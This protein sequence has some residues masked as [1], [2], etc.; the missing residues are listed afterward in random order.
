MKKTKRFSLIQSGFAPLI[1]ILVIAILGVMGYF[2]YKN[3]AQISNKTE[4]SNPSPNSVVSIPNL[5]S[6]LRGVPTYPNS[7]Y[8]PKYGKQE[9]YSSHYCGNQILCKAISYEFGTKDN[10]DSIFAWYK[11]QLPKGWK[12]IPTEKTTNGQYQNSYWG[13]TLIRGSET[14]FVNIDPSYG[15]AY[16]DTHNSTIIKP[17]SPFNWP[18]ASQDE[19]ANW[20]TFTSNDDLFTFKYPKDLFVGEGD[21]ITTIPYPSI[22]PSCG[23]V[24]SGL[25]IVVSQNTNN[26]TS[27]SYGLNSEKGDVPAAVI[28]KNKPSYFTGLDVSIFYG[29]GGAGTPGP[30]VY[31]ARNGKMIE[32]STDGVG[33]EKL[34]T[35]LSTL[36]FLN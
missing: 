19:I 16:M 23:G 2:V 11:T 5:P 7:F 10:T 25:G 29:M 15:N 9:F 35:I 14:Y 34:N 18:R 4:S 8:D 21:S 32:F 33:V 22:C 1:I 36:K 13:S 17:G 30:N 28:I 6:E 31:I 12:F 27:E 3:L 20:S 26:L 24:P